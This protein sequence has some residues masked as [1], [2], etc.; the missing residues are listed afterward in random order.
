MTDANVPS[1]LVLNLADNP[2]LA[3]ALSGKGP[4]DTCKLEVTLRIDEFSSDTLRGSI[5]EAVPDGYKTAEEPPED[6]SKSTESG[7]PSPIV[8]VLRA[9]NAS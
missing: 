7:S 1:S 9:K 4:G 3:D 2:D 5:T 8:A 6:E